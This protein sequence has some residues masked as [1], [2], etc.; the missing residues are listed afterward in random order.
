MRRLALIALAALAGC[1]GTHAA[2]P[3]PED[4]VRAAVAEFDAGLRAQDSRQLCASFSRQMLAYVE[5]IWHRPC[6]AVAPAVFHK[7][8]ETSRMVGTHVVSVRITGTKASAG[9]R[10]EPDGF[11]SEPVKLVREDGQ[12][13]LLWPAVTGGSSEYLGC[14]TRYQ[15]KLDADP[16]WQTVSHATIDE[17]TR[18]YCALAEKLP[19]ATGDEVANEIWFRMCVE[20]KLKPRLS[21]TGFRAPSAPDTLAG[22][23]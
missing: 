8:P 4:Q 12:W 19:T 5:S 1:G 13:K 3:S 2:G 15:R 21:Y 14:V 22:E 17:Y 9:V 18:R 16:D 23:V 7:M 11:R 10:A 6:E 20:H